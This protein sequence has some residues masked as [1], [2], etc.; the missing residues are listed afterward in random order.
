MPNRRDRV[1]EGLKRSVETAVGVGLAVCLSI[2]CSAIGPE[3]RPR[4]PGGL[5]GFDEMQ[6]GADRYQIAFSGSSASTRQQVEN[7]LMQRA[8]ELT[9]QAGYT[10]F[11]INTRDT[12]RNLRR[13]VGFIP[14][15]YLHGPDYFN[16]ARRWSHI[17]LAVEG[18]EANYTATAEIAMLRPDEA[19]QNVAAVS[20]VG[21]IQGLQP[22]PPLMIASTR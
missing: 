11:V 5:V 10:H 12:E 15:A 21:V 6:M 19:T 13:Q 14:D 8:A 4:P 16:R 2:G 7:F 17:P 1:F 20:A 3:Y 9:L 18:L 22:S